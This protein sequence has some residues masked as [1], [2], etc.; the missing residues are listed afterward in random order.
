M[1]DF[2][3]KFY[4]NERCVTGEKDCLFPRTAQR[5]NGRAGGTGVHHR[6]GLSVGDG[7]CS[8]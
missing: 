3:Y 1:C 4:S 2:V 6:A 5:I 7:E 8:N